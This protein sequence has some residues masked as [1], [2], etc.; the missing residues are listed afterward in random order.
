MLAA[1]R[2]TQQDDKQQTLYEILGVDEEVSSDALIKAYRQRALEEHP[3]KGGDAAHFDELVKA[4]KVLSVGTSREV[5]DQ[6]LAKSRERAM[7]V[8]GRAGRAYDAGVA[9]TSPGTV[10]QK[11]AQAPQRQKTEP[12][13]GSKRQAQMRTYQ[14]GKL[15]HCSDEWHGITSA[16]AYMKAITDDLT[17]P[18]KTERLFQQYAK[19]PPG[20]EKKQQWCNGLRG[21]EKTDL[22]ALA[23]KREQEALAKM[24]TWLNHGPSGAPARKQMNKEARDAGAGKLGSKPAAA[25]KPA[26]DSASPAEAAAESLAESTPLPDDDDDEL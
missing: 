14:P 4:F 2:E 15:G 16:T 7:L 24:S 17:E 25:R 23:K 19:L 9:A 20:K 10:S 18:Q 26:A 6:E 22:K 3:D 1:T 8:E 13:P 12:T 11:Q 5:Y 21:K